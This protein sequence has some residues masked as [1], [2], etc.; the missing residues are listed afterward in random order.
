MAGMPTSK[1]I[2]EMMGPRNSRTK[3]KMDCGFPSFASLYGSVFPACKR[4]GG[5]GQSMLW[6]FR[7]T[8]GRGHW[9]MGSFRSDGRMRRGRMVTSCLGGGAPKRSDG[10]NGDLLFVSTLKRRLSLAP[11]LAFSLQYGETTEC[12]SLVNS[13]IQRFVVP[14]GRRGRC[15][16]QNAS[17]GKKPLDPTVH[18]TIVNKQ[19][20]SG[21]LATFALQPTPLP[22]WWNW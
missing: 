3:D 17:Q 19:W 5:A 8:R 9:P 6:A 11:V 2:D 15:H 7:R 1:P 13:T 21:G 20:Q 4:R 18:V 12:S 14:L 10:R 22:G 16:E